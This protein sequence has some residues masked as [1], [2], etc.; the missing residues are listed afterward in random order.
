M[1][2]LLA[3]LAVVLVESPSAVMASPAAASRPPATLSLEPAEVDLGVV[4]F[5][6]PARAEFVVRNPTDAAVELRLEA[7]KGLRVEGLPARVAPH[8]SQRLTVTADTRATPGPQQLALRIATGAA[9]LP[10]L[11]ASL[12]LDVRAFL[13]VTPGYAR[14]ITVRHAREGTLPQTVMATDGA[15]FRVLDVHVPVP[16]LRMAFHE[17]RTAE[18]RPDVPGSQWRVDLTLASDA[19]VGALMGEVEIVTDHPRQKRTFLELSGFVRPVFAVTPPAPQLGD[20]APGTR[21]LTLFVK[22]FAEE[23]LALQSVE[24]GTPSLRAQ[25]EP[26]ESGHTW[27]V[28]LTVPDTAPAGAFSTRL[29]LLTNHPQVPVIEV[30][31]SG[32]VTSP[33]AAPR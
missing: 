32:R 28:R 20:V 22:N 2:W 29:R 24:T 25:I 15:A 11:A 30:P 16:H 21:S 5:A 31:V 10:V 12:R 1:S 13:A 33:V 19:P 14:Y 27:R 18:R 8:G 9:D 6:E 7:T 17:A 26:V 4:G 3:L 23:S